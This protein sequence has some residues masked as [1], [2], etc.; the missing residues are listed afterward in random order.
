VSGGLSSS[1]GKMATLQSV[2]ET[3]GLGTPFI[4]GGITFS[5]FHWLD[6]N[7]SAKATKSISA[8]LKSRPLEKIDVGDATISLF[9]RVYSSP[10]FRYRAF[11]RSAT[12]SLFIWAAFV[13]PNA[14]LALIVM[15]HDYNQFIFVLRLFID[16][17]ISNVITIVLADYVSLF[18]VRKTL[19]IQT[20]STQGNQS[21]ICCWCR[22]SYH[23]LFVI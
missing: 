17:F 15:S 11:G 18:A 13:L 8:W 9:D 1:A 10:L 3:L 2:L 19:D 23:I 16:R 21:G 12:I 14:I 22:N 6:R 4:Y 20:I 5:V 7:A